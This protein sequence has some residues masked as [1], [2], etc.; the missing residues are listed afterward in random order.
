MFVDPALAARI[1][2]GEATMIA[3]I[4]RAA[5]ARGAPVHA[6]ELCGGT[7]FVAEPGSP[8]T[9]VLGAGLP[10]AG[11][12][13]PDDDGLDAVEAVAGARGVSVRFE[14]ASLAEPELLGWLT[15]RGYQLLGFENVLLRALDTT[16]PAEEGVAVDLVTPETADEWLHA[17]LAGFGA[18]DGT[19]ADADAIPETTEALET[20][21]RDFTRAEGLYHWLARIDGAVVGSGGLFVAGPLAWLVGAST[22]APHRR[23]GVQRSLTA[24]R[25]R[26]AVSAGC[27]LAITTTSPGSQSQANA[28]RAGFSIGYTR[29]VLMQRSTGRVAVAPPS[30]LSRLVPRRDYLVGD[31]EDLV[32]IDWSDD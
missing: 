20:V 29:A 3:A 16:M 21:F 26:C 25:L 1:D 19:G 17:S 13:G 27:R 31:P 28:M 23:R 32:Q 12:A 15:G 4:A 14:V 24:A 2:R 8:L 11:P 9:K 18:D 30:K 6:A 5:A 7:A 10:G 22:L